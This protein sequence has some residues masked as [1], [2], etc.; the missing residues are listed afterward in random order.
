MGLFVTPIPEHLLMRIFYFRLI[1][2]G[3]LCTFFSVLASSQAPFPTQALDLGK[4]SARELKAGEVH[5]YSL[6][7][8]AEQI[9]EIIIDQA[10]SDVM[11]MVNNFR[12]AQGKGSF[13]IVADRSREYRIEMRSEDAVAGHYSIKLVNIRTASED[14]QIPKTFDLQLPSSGDRITGLISRIA[15]AKTETEG[16]ALLAAYPELI[17]LELARGVN[18]EGERLAISQGPRVKVLFL[19]KT[20]L[21]IAE[22]LDDKFT[23][24]SAY[25]NLARVHAD[26]FQYDLAVEYGLKSIPLAEKLGN[27]PNLLGYAYNQ[28][29]RGYMGKVEHDRALEYFVKCVSLLER[30]NSGARNQ[31]FNLSLAYWQAGNIY[32]LKGELERALEYFQKSIPI[33]TEMGNKRDVVLLLFNISEC[34]SRMGDFNAAITTLTKSL[35]LAEALGNK[36][37]KVVTL[38]LLS[39]VYL[40]QGLYAKELETLESALK[41]AEAMGIVKELGGS[42]RMIQLRDRIGLAHLRLG[43]TAQAIATL[44][45][46]LK[47]SERSDQPTMAGT[48]LIHLGAALRVQGHDQYASEYY[49]RAINLVQADPRLLK[50]TSGIAYL[51]TCYNSLGALQEA[52]GDLGSA[53][54]FYQK[55]RG[56]LES[57]PAEP[58]SSLGIQGI[59]YLL[60]FTQNYIGEIYFKQAQYPEALSYYQQAAAFAEKIGHTEG[61][62]DSQ[63]HLGEVYLV[64]GHFEQGLE[65]TSRAIELARHPNFS[66]LSLYNDHARPTNPSYQL[67]RSLTLQGKIFRALDRPKEADNA[68]A[69]A[70]SVIESARLN[71]QTAEERASY[72][73]KMQEPFDQYVELLMELHARDSSKGFNVRAFEIVERQHARSLLESLSEERSA[74]RKDIDPSLLRQ[75]TEIRHQLNARAGNQLLVQMNIHAE[76][77]NEPGLVST[78]SM[79]EAV[80]EE[81]LAR[82]KVEVDNLT[83][84]YQNIQAQIRKLSPHYADLTQPQPIDIETI[85]SEILDADT[86]LLEYALGEKK[87][88]LWAVAKDTVTSYE[89]PP[90][91]EIEAAVRRAYAFLSDGKLVADPHKN[92]NYEQE[93]GHL[94]KQLLAPVA[95]RLQNKRILVV[96]D[97]ALQFLPFGALPVNYSRAGNSLPLNATNEIIIL[98]SIS[99]LAVLRRIISGRASAAKSV[100]VLADPVFTEQDERLT[101]SKIVPPK[102]ANRAG[103]DRDNQHLFLER[104][105]DLGGDKKELLTLLRLPFSRREA[106]GILAIAPANSSLKALDF[107]ASLDTALDGELSN[108]RI[109]HFAT[110]GLLNS[111]HPELSGLVLSLVNAKGEPVNGFL[112]LNEI[113]NLNLNADLVVLSACQTAL[114]KEVRGEGLIGLTRGFMYAGSPRVVASLWKVDDVATAELMKIFYQ[115]MLKDKM[116]PAAALRAAK[117]AM[118]KT[119]RWNSPYYW[120]AFELQGD[121]R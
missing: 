56:L 50:S 111:E 57:V 35:E 95:E 52:Q 90:R 116:R 110:H 66:V 106:E 79:D 19:F 81:R 42:W 82:L 44:Q 14:S 18:R 2:A 60:V 99:T 40:S 117:V 65:I 73:A 51:A 85:R 38:Y 75:E 16:R 114:G 12:Y 77:D 20:L 37:L 92:I 74:I 97:G 68:F 104:A 24:A 103:V 84:E 76:G 9:A 49:Q 27:Y 115:K 39:G 102:N 21:K 62:L 46:V 100:A 87:S 7:L 13:S 1:F 59:Q 113:Y 34:N 11:A 109:I 93:A 94:S 25:A 3:V 54:A 119:K 17:T 118:W 69:E 112:R 45:S 96:A 48:V 5:T 23:L 64:Q 43:N 61:L 71:V 41:V 15:S 83:L 120:A 70:I 105:L 28:A 86:I 80:R 67:W 32:A 30:H 72:F 8:E 121:W 89:L 4:P 26:R 10:T 91:A 107:N 55:T 6:Q 108:Y 88:Y 22:L 58:N 78:L 101:A 31:R 63:I 98:P 33:R 36:D 53:L 29:G 47:F